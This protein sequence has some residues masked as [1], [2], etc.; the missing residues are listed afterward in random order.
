[1][2]S[3]HVG[4]KRPSVKEALQNITAKTLVIG[5]SSDILFPVCEQEFLAENIPGAEYQYIDSLYG[6]DGFLV[7]VEKIETV[8]T[9]FYK[10]SN[11]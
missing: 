7:E 9:N 3:H 5:I 8:I 10:K 2:D 4:R 11:P 6:H 1:M